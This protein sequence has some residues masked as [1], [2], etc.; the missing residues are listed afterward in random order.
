MKVL[1]ICASPR[2]SK[3]TTLRL[4]Q[5]A[6]E[7]AKAGGAGVDLVDVCDLDIK[8]CTGCQ[9]CA[10]ACPFDAISRMDERKGE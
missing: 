3:S 1:V 2:G 5:A 6:L 8:Y 9:V 7:G 4:V 10:Q